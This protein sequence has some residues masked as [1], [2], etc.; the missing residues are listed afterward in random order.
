MDSGDRGQRSTGTHSQRQRDAITIEIAFALFSGAL[1]A[2]LL[3][4]LIKS[5]AL[6]GDLGERMEDRFHLAATGVAA[7]G[8]SL[9]TT[10]L[11]INLRASLGGKR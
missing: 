5:P 7:T 11:L 1:V 6:L 4:F 2:A 10:T 8:F 9:R 3:F